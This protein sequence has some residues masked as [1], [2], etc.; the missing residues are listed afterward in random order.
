[1]MVGRNDSVTEWPWNEMIVGETMLGEMIAELI[2]S[3]VKL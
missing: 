1:M 3:G 2:D